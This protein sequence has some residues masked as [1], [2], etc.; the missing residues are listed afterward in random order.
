MT[1][2]S[3]HGKTG[4]M[5]ISLFTYDN[6]DQSWTPD[7]EGELTMARI[8]RAIVI[9]WSPSGLD[10]KTLVPGLGLVPSLALEGPPATVPT[11]KK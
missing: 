9:A 7:N 10:G 4:P 2:P 8:A 1:W 3:S 5:I 6:K 11:S